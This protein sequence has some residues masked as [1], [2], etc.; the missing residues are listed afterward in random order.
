[1]KKYASTKEIKEA[2][3]GRRYLTGVSGSQYEMLFLVCSR[4]SCSHGD[5]KALS[6]PPLVLDSYWTDGNQNTD[7]ILLA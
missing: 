1:M 2:L 5:W 7:L 4:Q 3:T 6:Y